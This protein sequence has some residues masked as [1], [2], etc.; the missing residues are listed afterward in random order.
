MNVRPVDY[1][2]HIRDCRARLPFR[3]GVITMTAAPLCLLRITAEMPAGRMEGFASDLLVPKWFVKDPTA[4]IEEDWRGLIAGVRSA[5]EEAI[6][7][8]L[9]ANV[10]DHWSAADVPPGLQH[11]HGPSLVERALIDVVCR[12]SGVGFVRAIAEDLLGL[13]VG[14][15]DPSLAEWRPA[16]AI[17]STARTTAALRHTVGLADALVAE[18]ITERVDDGL[19]ECLAED[20]ERYGLTHFKVKIAG[21]QGVTE[22]LAAV[23]RVVR[24]SAGHA[25]AF[26]LDA[27]E[28]APS[29]DAL[30][31]A[32]DQARR[33]ADAAWL[34]ERVLFIEQPLSRRH[35]FDPAACAGLDRLDRYGGCIIDEADESLDAAPRAAALGYRGVSVK[36]CKG[37]IRAIIN[38]GRCET[39]GIM[40]SGEDLT[41]LPVVALQQDLATVAALALPLQ[42][43][44][45]QH[46]RHRAP[47]LIVPMAGPSLLL[48]LFHHRG[49]RT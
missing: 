33:D 4:P 41:N 18:D 25:A 36:N 38:R 37:V 9:D 15:A 34:L 19:P 11:A 22:R 35:S 1:S 24:T 44:L 28:Q 39:A 5:A 23:A 46:P 30:A 31:D 42:D 27:N 49:Q 20:I 13:R 45:V 32:L 10:F 2:I 8:G 6:G 14:E 47:P 16:E 7:R 17:A 29:A 3:F 21:S 43:L 48:E 40:Q 12:G 26:T